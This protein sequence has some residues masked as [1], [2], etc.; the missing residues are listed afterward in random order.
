MNIE[1]TFVVKKFV[2]GKDHM[3]TDPENGTKSICSE[4]KVC[5][6]TKE[7]QRVTFWLQRI[8]IRISLTEYL[9]CFNGNLRALSCA[10]R[11]LKDS[12]YRYCC[13]GSYFCKL[14]FRKFG[15][16]KYKLNI[17]YCRTIVKGNKSHIL[18]GAL[19]AYPSHQS[20]LPIITRARE[21]LLYICLFHIKND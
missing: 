19:C 20:D 13:S 4:T 7:L 1:K 21:E 10:N 9:Q 2:Y 5:N 17:I 14:F 11:L 3:V 18:T 16:I 8:L 12:C 15:S 6:L